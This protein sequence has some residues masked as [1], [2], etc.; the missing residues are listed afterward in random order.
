MIIIIIIMP[1]RQ[2][3]HEKAVISCIRSHTATANGPYRLWWGVQCIHGPVHAGA[4]DI[5][6]RLGW[7]VLITACRTIRRHQPPYLP[8]QVFNGGN[9]IDP[10]KHAQLSR[11]I[12]SA[13]RSTQTCS[14]QYTYLLSTTQH[15]NM[16]NSIHLFAQHY[17]ACNMGSRD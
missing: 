15:S 11:P 4:V 17:A 16:L 5:S 7:S 2:I 13:L 10:A 12:R 3:Y 1:T 14:T 9:R 6:H 8:V